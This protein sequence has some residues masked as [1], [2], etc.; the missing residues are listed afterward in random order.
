MGESHLTDNDF[1][2]VPKGEFK[3]IYFRLGG[4]PASGWTAEYWQKFFEVNA[5]P[6]WKFMVQEPAGPDHDRMWIVTDHAKKEYRLFFLNEKSTED[7]F[8]FPGKGNQQ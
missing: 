4:A 3:D 2:E 1:R 6:G 7:V 8:D 5:R